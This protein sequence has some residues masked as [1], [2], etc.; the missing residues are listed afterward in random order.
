MQ[1]LAD[2]PGEMWIGRRDN[3]PLGRFGLVLDL[4]DSSQRVF[5]F[6]TGLF[7]A[8]EPEHLIPMLGNKLTGE[9]QHPARRT[10]SD[11]FTGRTHHFLT[12]RWNRTP[13]PPA[14]VIHGLALTTHRRLPEFTLCFVLVVLP[15]ANR[16][17]LLVSWKMRC[18]HHSSFSS[19]S[20]R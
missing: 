18:R 2:A 5:G 16:S 6:E 10:V 15:S 9:Q 14:L 1:G 12:L 17:I 3:Q 7:I 4:D 11:P 20:E 19:S 8:G 13:H